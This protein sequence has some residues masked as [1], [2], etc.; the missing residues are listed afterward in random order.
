MRV[1][2]KRILNLIL[3]RQAVNE[4]GLV[5][6]ADEVLRKDIV[7]VLI[8][9]DAEDVPVGVDGAASGTQDDLT[10][11]MGRTQSVMS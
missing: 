5:Y 4:V 3:G 8:L 2:G 7:D 10:A 9:V 1:V 11:G 6:V